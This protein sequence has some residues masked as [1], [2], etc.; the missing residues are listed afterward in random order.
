[1]SLGNV[2][3]ALDRGPSSVSQRDMSGRPFFH[4]RR[5]GRGWYSGHNSQNAPALLNFSLYVFHQ[6]FGLAGSAWHIVLAQSELL[7]LCHPFNTER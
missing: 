5:S 7:S 4:Y 6:I 2:C 1:M 3:Y